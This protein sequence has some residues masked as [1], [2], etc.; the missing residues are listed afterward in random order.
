[1]PRPVSYCKLS[2]CH[3]SFLR[4]CALPGRGHD[5]VES[6]DIVGAR[7]DIRSRPTISRLAPTTTREGTIP[8]RVVRYRGPMYP[9][10]VRYYRAAHGIA[11]NH[12]IA[13]SH[14]ISARGHDIGALPRY[15]ARYDIANRTTKRA[16]SRDIVT[17]SSRARQY[18][19]YFAQTDEWWGN[20]RSVLRAPK[21]IACSSLKL[22]CPHSAGAARAA[23]DALP[24]SSNSC[25]RRGRPGRL[26]AARPG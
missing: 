19:S 20:V 25:W 5:I 10:Y 18:R 3:S 2:K 17:P 15:R 9:C 6:H 7:G 11:D 24:A 23:S 13:A 21:E 14:T 12:D 26:A 8:R 16:E 4:D 1:M 22:R